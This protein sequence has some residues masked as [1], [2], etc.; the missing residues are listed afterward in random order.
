MNQ[1]VMII[2]AG[3]SG[4]TL[5]MFLKKAGMDCAVYENFP[6][7]RVEGS[8]FRINKSGVHVMK[9]LGIEDQAQQ[10]SHSAD[11][12][13]ILTTDDMEIASINLMQDS[14]FSRRSIYMQRSDLVEI[15]MRQAELDGVE[16]HYNKK[17]THFTQDASN[18]TAYFEDGHQET[19]TLL[20]GADGL[21]STVRN[22]L[23]PSHVL[24][25]A[26]SWGLYGL[27]SFKDMNSD[28]IRH[29]MDGD[30]LFYFTQ[31]ANFLVSKSNPTHELNL[32]WQASGY[33]ERK[34]SKE[35]F[36]FRTLD[37]IKSDLIQE[38]GGN[39]ALS[40]IIR[41]SAH[42]IPKQIYSV[43]PIPSWSKGRAVVIGD[44]A[45]TINPNTGYGCSVALEDAM[46]LA[47]M[48]KKHHYTDALYYL[49]ADR[50]ERI[51]AI[52]GSLDIFD[53]SKGFD[54]SN[55]F[56]IGLFSGSKIDAN[57]TIHWETECL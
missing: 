9:E 16:I 37:E 31:N 47:K 2:G 23:F 29:L 25:Y 7:K 22:Q 21:H 39:G 56:D 43:D 34:R 32:S 35:E 45:H 48:L 28:P 51:R 12:M 50:K 3:I 53:V 24:S 11:R 52:L 6:Y 14:V 26:K 1:K 30:E 55:G 42:I 49:E 41:N 20:V 33:Q 27:A 5:A 4:L 36:E 18:I 40:E 57:Y 46:Y 17:L 10:N 44:A 54:F 15:L 8:S 19:G 38:Y 13:R